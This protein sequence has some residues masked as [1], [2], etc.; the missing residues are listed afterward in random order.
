MKTFDYINNLEFYVGKIGQKDNDELRETLAAHKRH[1]GLV[2]LIH[3]FIYYIIYLHI[4]N[5]I[6]ICIY[7]K[8][9]EKIQ[10]ESRGIKM[11]G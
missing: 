9:T 8:E 10:Q 1:T 11:D 5:V 4:Y 7:V 3:I 2:S 6:Y